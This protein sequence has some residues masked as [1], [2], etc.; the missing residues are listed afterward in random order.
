MTHGSRCSASYGL[1]APPR[2][3][4]TSR[5]HF[6]YAARSC[7]GCCGRLGHLFGLEAS[8]YLAALLASVFPCSSHAIEG[9]DSPTSIRSRSS[10]RYMDD[11]SLDQYSTYLLVHELAKGPF[12]IATSPRIRLGAKSAHANDYLCAPRGDYDDAAAHA[13]ALDMARPRQPRLRSRSVILRPRTRLT[14]TPI[15]LMGNYTSPIYRT[16]LCPRPMV[17]GTAGTSPRERSPADR[18]THFAHT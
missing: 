12:A 17:E 8:S 1:E 3:S 10:A 18:H 15:S 11:S 13:A 5:S 14:D 2:T 6:T 16:R 7:F 4:L 9:T